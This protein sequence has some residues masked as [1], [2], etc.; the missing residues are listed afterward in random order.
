VYKI[1]NVYSPAWGI[2]VA[3]FDAEGFFMTGDLVYI[4]NHFI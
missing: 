2:T 4:L 1:A 3:F